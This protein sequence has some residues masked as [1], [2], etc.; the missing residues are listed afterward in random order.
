MKLLIVTLTRMLAPR[1]QDS[2]LATSSNSWIRE[3]TNKYLPNKRLWVPFS[4]TR[5]SRAR[6]SEHEGRE[7]AHAHSTPSVPSCTALEKKG[8]IELS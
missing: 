1:E 4:R 5:V 6:F 3:P 2:S 8:Y 7:S